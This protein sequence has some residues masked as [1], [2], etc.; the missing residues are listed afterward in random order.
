VGVSH[1]A[2]FAEAGRQLVGARLFI[3]R[4]RGHVGSFVVGRGQA[5]TLVTSL[6]GVDAEVDLRAVG[7][8]EREGAA[9]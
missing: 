2:A 5:R 7:E 3:P 8:Q 1:R 9:E 4:R 6:M